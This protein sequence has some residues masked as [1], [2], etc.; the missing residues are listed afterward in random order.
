MAQRAL[1]AALVVSAI[2]SFGSTARGQPVDTVDVSDVDPAPT[3]ETSAPSPPP[4]SGPSLVPAAPLPCVHPCC[5]HL[6]DSETTDAELKGVVVG[7]VTTAIVSYLFAS[8]FASTQ[9]H[10]SLVDGIPI[11]GAI[12]SVAHN[13]LDDQRTPV[14]L[15][16]AALQTAGVLLAVASGVELKE[17]R[18]YRID[19][20]ACPYGA[21]VAITVRY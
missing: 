3:E 21:S 10:F 6:E 17:R 14:L 18:R 20:G 2:L 13:R 4:T 1:A 11:V 12:T 7:G 15:F 9:P 8:V 19:V 5:C 16:S